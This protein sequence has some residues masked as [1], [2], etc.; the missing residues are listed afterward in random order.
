ML[1]PGA[2]NPAGSPPKFSG[3]PLAYR[4]W[5]SSVDGPAPDGGGWRALVK[6]YIEGESLAVF[7]Q[8]IPG[9]SWIREWLGRSVY[10]VLEDDGDPPTP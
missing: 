4:I 2:F 8:A 7:E 6:D 5:C 9:F 3:E 10:C 1:F